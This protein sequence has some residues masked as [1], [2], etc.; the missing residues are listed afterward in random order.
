MDIMKFLEFSSKILHY[1][2]FFGQTPNQISGNAVGHYVF[3]LLIRTM[4]V[5]AVSISSTCL[6]AA[7][8]LGIPKA[9]KSI[10]FDSVF[11]CFLDLL[12]QNML[13]KLL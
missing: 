8:T 9:Q 4:P 11:W 13:V 5:E 12:A 2:R 3:H 6:N 10:L 7:F 1:Q